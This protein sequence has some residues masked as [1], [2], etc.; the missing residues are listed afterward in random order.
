MNLLDVFLAFVGLIAGFRFW[1]LAIYAAAALSGLIAATQEVAQSAE[2]F[3][4]KARRTV[5]MTSGVWFG[6]FSA[7]AYL[8]RHAGKHPAAW[9]SL[10]GGIACTSCVALANYFALRRKRA[11]MVAEGPGRGSSRAVP[12]Q[13]GA[14]YV[15]V[16]SRFDRAVVWLFLLAAI[17]VFGVG[18]YA[19]F[20]GAGV[21]ANLI[22]LPTAVGLFWL[23]IWLFR[24]TRNRV[25]VGDRGITQRRGAFQAFVPW[26]GVSS[27]REAP[28]PISVIFQGSRGEEVRVDKKLVGLS[29]LIEYAELHLTPKLYFSMLCYFRP[30]TA[31]AQHSLSHAPT[32]LAAENN[33]GEDS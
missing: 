21:L 20:N 16:H 22:T 23:F 13:D 32:Q 25:E 9:I 5:L 6:V 24:F 29:T 19:P 14:G 10:F 2:V 8:L 18:V 11:R 28:F 26:S 3:N 33:S 27:I 12:L 1:P 31:L 17:A 15:L 7:I 30:E 4:R